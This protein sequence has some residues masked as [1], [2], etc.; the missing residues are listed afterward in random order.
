M[1]FILSQ[2]DEYFGVAK[3]QAINRGDVQVKAKFSGLKPLLKGPSSKRG[4]KASLKRRA[5]HLNGG[6]TNLKEGAIDRRHQM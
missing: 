4:L 6:T 2:K 3:V 5:S 1:Y